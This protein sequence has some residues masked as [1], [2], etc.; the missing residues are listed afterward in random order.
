MTRGSTRLLALRRLVPF[1]LAV[2]VPCLAMALPTAAGAGE[3]VRVVDNPSGPGG[4]VLPAGTFRLDLPIDALMR[5][6]MERHLPF[7][8]RTTITVTQTGPDGK[9]RRYEF[10]TLTI[11]GLR[12]DGPAGPLVV[13]AVPGHLAGVIAAAKADAG[14]RVEFGSLFSSEDFRLDLPPPEPE[15]R[16]P[17][18]FE[19]PIIRCKQRGDGDGPGERV[20]WR[21]VP[22]RIPNR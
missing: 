9:V 2:L 7:G 1:I 16:K 17:G 15:R 14:S 21:K 3:R 10:K 18:L 13:L 4:Y 6:E 12:D 22:E 20:C 8:Q 11:I 19:Y 5:F